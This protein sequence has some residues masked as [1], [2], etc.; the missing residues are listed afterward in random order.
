MEE[1]K[2]C[3]KC[4]TKKPL[5]DFTFQ[6]KKSGNRRP[7]SWCRKCTYEYR[8]QYY[9]ANNEQR[10]KLKLA[11]KQHKAALSA[12]LMEVKKNPCADCG[13]S[14]P[15][16][17]MDFDHRDPSQKI[18]DVGTMRRNGVTMEVLKAEVAKCDLVCAVCHRI[19]T[20]RK[21][22]GPETYHAI[23][24]ITGHSQD[25]GLKEDPQA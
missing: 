17:A 21:K 14:F 12:Y 22:Y 10:T 15:F 4:K 20:H 1:L 8:R 13:R 19:R 16:Y 11:N 7:R 9:S 24:L 2:V 25:G 5:S 6:K 3:R 23:T 18:T